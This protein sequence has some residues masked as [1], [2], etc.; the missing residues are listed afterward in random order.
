M[1]TNKLSTY[2]I[3]HLQEICQTL[4]CKLLSF[5]IGDFLRTFMKAAVVV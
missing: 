5:D 4:R 3:T 1:E 2:K